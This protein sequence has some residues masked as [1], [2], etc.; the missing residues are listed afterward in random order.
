MKAYLWS[1]LFCVVL[2]LT[3]GLST[4]WLIDPYALYQHP[5][6]ALFSR[7]TAAAD[8]GRT[9]KSYQVNQQDVVSLIVGN[10]R[11]EL[12]MPEHHP[13][14]DGAVFNMGLPGAGVL[15][16]YDY[17]WHAVKTNTMIK[18]VLVAVDFVDFLGSKGG[19]Q[20]WYGNWQFR[21]DY[22]LGDKTTLL[23]PNRKRYLERL[24]LV[25]SQDAL[26]DAALTSLQQQRDVNAL[27]YYGFNDGALYR[28]V[29][30]TESYAA[31]YQ[32]K[33]QELQ[34]RL[35]N[36]ALVLVDNSAAIQALKRFLSLLQQEQI[37]VVLFINP[38]Q[39]PYLE[40]IE[41]AGLADEM[42]RWKQQI[43]EIAK[44]YNID[45]YDFAIESVPVTLPAPLQSRQPD[46]NPYF[47]EPAHYKTHLGQLMLNAMQQKQCQQS[48]DGV[49]VELCRH[50]SSA[51]GQIKSNQTF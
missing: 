7:K 17:A 46:D 48:I 24:S 36:P 50:F 39:Q 51:V 32:Q 30:R 40:L 21:L 27:N 45:L 26:I 47:W 1:F 43:V 14:Y 11:V 4:S 16:Q 13:F 33:Q 2:I 5:E 25:F 35:A 23:P 49:S 20:N 41:Q 6:Q 19:E 37:E 18:Q 34:T 29:V 42:T 31:L 38:Y 9:I 28:H 15:M 3:I 44:S 22:R 8:K 12:G 10:S